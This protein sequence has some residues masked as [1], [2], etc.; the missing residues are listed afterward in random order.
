MTLDA[1]TRAAEAGADAA[2]VRT[3]SYYDVPASALEN[4]YRDLAAKSQQP[5]YLYSS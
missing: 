2:L 4:Y 1:T 5:I 3:P